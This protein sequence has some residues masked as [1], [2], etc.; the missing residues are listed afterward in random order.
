MRKIQLI[1]RGR[2]C[3]YPCVVAKTPTRGAPTF[4]KI[5]EWV[6]VGLVPTPFDMGRAPTGSTPTRRAPTRRA[7]TRRAPTRGAPTFS[8]IDRSVGVGLVPTLIRYRGNGTHKGCPYVFPH[9]WVG[10]GRS[11]AYPCVVGSAVI[12]SGKYS[13]WCQPFTG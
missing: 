9:S 4:A 8:K 7:P 2:S 1:R 10:R 12:K 11:C 13:G 3:A 5:D 6:G